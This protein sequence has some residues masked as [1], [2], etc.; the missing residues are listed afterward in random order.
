MTREVQLPAERFYW[1]L[2]D[3]SKLVGSRRK[4]DEAL[5]Y[6]FEAQIPE[7]LEEVHAVFLDAGNSRF[8]ACGIPK[9]VIHDE[10]P[11]ECVTSVPSTAPSFLGV[12]IEAKRFNVLTRAFT[13]PLV[14]QARRRI[15]FEAMVVLALA[16][17]L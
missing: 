1:A 17:I 12:A 13:P 14:K 11:P 15:L 5:S 10:I 7:P 6:L 3:G 16:T 4:R 9:R 2:L 8:V